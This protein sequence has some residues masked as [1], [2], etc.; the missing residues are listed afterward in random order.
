[1][2]VRISRLSSGNRAN[3]G[4]RPSSQYWSSRHS[5]ARRASAGLED[6]ARDHTFRPA[7]RP[8]PDAPPFAFGLAWRTS[9]C[10]TR[11]RTF[12]VTTGELVTA[13]GGPTATA[14]R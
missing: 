8:A 12:V 13:W 6:L 14:Q 2:L 10:T 5:Y 1:V 3:A 4:F 7:G 9:A 11:V